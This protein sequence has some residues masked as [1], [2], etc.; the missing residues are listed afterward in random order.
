MHPAQVRDTQQ[1]HGL[2]GKRAIFAALALLVVLACTPAVPPPTPEPTPIAHPTGSD[3]LVLRIETSGGLIPPFRL[4][5]E[6]PQLSV[7]GDGTVVTLGPQITIYPPPALLNVLQ[8]RITE[9]GLQLLL[10]EAAAAGLLAGDAD[11]PLEGIYDAPTTFFT[12]NAGGRLSHVS[13]YALGLEDPSDPRLTPEQRAARQRLA[14]FARKARDLYSWLP[15]ETVVER[16]IPFTITRLQVVV[17]PA[18][19][20]EAPHLEDEQLVTTRSW[21][22]PTPL[23]AFGEPAPWF[24]TSARCGVVTSR[25]EL[26]RL[27]EQVQTAN[28][29]TRWASEG[30]NYVLFF[31]PVLPDETGC[32]PPQLRA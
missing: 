22:L 15:S 9:Q 10:R 14:E 29:L 13:V 26:P 2:D 27:L 25:K 31:R 28:L 1:G 18:N 16:D 17:L 6:F 19:A 12:V 8:G 20:P 5:T 3:E 32:Q 7:Y 24:G 23:S 30:R 4:P 21:P 11:Y